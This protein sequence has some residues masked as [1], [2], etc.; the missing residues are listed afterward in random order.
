M[1]TTFLTQEGFDKMQEE[2]DQLIQVK[3][4]ENAER[5]REAIEGGDLI[6]NAEYEAAKREQAFTEGR[7]K[8]LHILLA[9]ARVIDESKKSTD[10]VAL[11]SVVTIQEKGYDPEVYKILGAAEANPRE[12]KISNES[13]IGGALLGS[14]VGDIVQI[15]APETSYKVKVLKIE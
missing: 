9:S 11:G 4:V 2:F 12:G 6:D 10:K 15:N 3:R 7:V 1:A 13:P 8:E 5:L 14:K